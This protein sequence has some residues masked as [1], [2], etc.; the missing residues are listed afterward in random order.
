MIIWF[1]KLLPSTLIKQTRLALTSHIPTQT[2]KIA[3]TIKNPIP[4]NI[5]ATGFVRVA[6]LILRQE[7]PRLS[8]A[9][10]KNIIYMALI[11]GSML[12]L[13]SN[14]VYTKIKVSIHPL[15]PSII[16]TSLSSNRT[17]VEISANARNVKNLTFP[18]H[19]I[20]ER[21]AQLPV[22]ATSAKKT[23]SSEN[24]NATSTRTS[25]SRPLRLSSHNGDFNRLKG[26]ETPCGQ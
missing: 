3:I 24:T 17:T 18:P 10:N 15:I 8:T 5:R 16:C 11:E 20:V 19:P 7:Q 14:F 9:D 22:G 21:T 4:S 13:V 25:T 2:N 23:R 1:F 6:F 12:S 26:S